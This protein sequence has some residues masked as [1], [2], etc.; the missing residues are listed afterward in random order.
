MDKKLKHFRAD[1]GHYIFVILAQ[2]PEEAAQIFELKEHPEKS[3]HKNDS[4]YK[5][6]K[7]TTPQFYEVTL[8]E[9]CKCCGQIIE[10]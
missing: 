1:T 4:A 5:D 2:S 7:F 9:K 8:P 6:F 10:N 3:Y